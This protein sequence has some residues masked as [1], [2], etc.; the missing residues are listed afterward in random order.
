VVL[1]I[2][3]SKLRYPLHIAFLVLHVIGIIPGL[4]YTSR[5]PD[6]Y[7]GSSHNNLGW[8]LTALVSAHFLVG[9][10]KS[11][12]KHGEPDTDHELTPFISSENVEGGNPSSGQP[13]QGLSPRAS[14]PIPRRSNR[15]SEETDSET[16]LDVHL[17]Y[18]SRREHRFD[19]PMSWKRRWLNILEPH[20]LIQL[21]DIGYDVVLRFFLIL[22]FV[23]ICT[24]IVTMAGIFVRV[25]NLIPRPL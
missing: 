20:F 22:G 5:T 6:L 18:N 8:L 14:S 21:L 15:S 24:G 10:S 2:A 7:T 9:V 3:G 25:W 4:I 16:L 13:H 12:T 23:G 17:H 11:F 19:E 1:H